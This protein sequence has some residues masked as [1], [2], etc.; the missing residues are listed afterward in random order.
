MLED[1]FVGIPIYNF[2]YGYLSIVN[3]KIFALLMRGSDGMKF[4]PLDWRVAG[5][6]L[7]LLKE[8]WFYSIIALILFEIGVFS[9]I[10]RNFFNPIW[11]CLHRI[12]NAICSKVC[13]C[14]NK[15]EAVNIM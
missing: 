8:Q 7:Y 9:F 12:C 5:K 1:W 15:N 10:K 2:N 11:N 4:G 13:C 14:C 3:R 6:P